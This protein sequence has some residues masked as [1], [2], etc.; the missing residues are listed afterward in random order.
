MSD[1]EVRPDLDRVGEDAL[2][3][4]LGTFLGWSVAELPPSAG[5]AGAEAE[6]WLQA[7]VPLTGPRLSGCLQIQLPRAFVAE[8]VRRLA[9]PTHRAPVGD[10]EVEDLAGELGNMLAGQVTARLRIQGYSCEL[11]LPQVAAVPDAQPSG[12]SRTVWS[13][14]GHRLTLEIRLRCL[15]P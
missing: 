11:G 7:T 4:V 9:L 2:R 1:F 14:H 6:V 3:E 5:V 10:T 15:P 12:H 8:A 13:C